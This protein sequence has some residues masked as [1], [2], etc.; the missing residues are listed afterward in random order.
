MCW[1]SCFL[2]ELIDEQDSAGSEEEYA[3]GTSKTSLMEVSVVLSKHLS[4]YCAFMLQLL[5]PLMTLRIASTTSLKPSS[6]AIRSR[7]PWSYWETSMHG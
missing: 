2:Q 4:I 3:M 5:Q 7:K 1:L 6:K